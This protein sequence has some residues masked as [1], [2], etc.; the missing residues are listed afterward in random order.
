MYV[1]VFP[2]AFILLAIAQS[3]LWVSGNTLLENLFFPPSSSFSIKLSLTIN[4]ISALAGKLICFHRTP[5]PTKALKLMARNGKMIV[6]DEEDKVPE[7]SLWIM[8]STVFPRRTV[9][10]CGTRINNDST[11]IKKWVKEKEPDRLT[12]LLGLIVSVKCN[13]SWVCQDFN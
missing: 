2:A 10:R 7:Y 11:P 5:P 4:H 9:L 6:L 8:M 12:S 13:L 1:H 3:G